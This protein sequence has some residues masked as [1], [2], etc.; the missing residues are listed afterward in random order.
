MISESGSSAS[1]LSIDLESASG[2]NSG[3]ALASGLGCSAS[4]RASC[5]TSTS[6]LVTTLRKRK[7][8]PQTWALNKRRQLRNSGNV[9]I[10]AKATISTLH[11]SH[12]LF[13]YFS[14]MCAFI[15][16]STLLF[17]PHYSLSTY[18]V[19]HR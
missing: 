14:L 12:A 9:Y 8:K 2:A 13:R 18:V 7:R 4:M 1:N 15:M 10:S 16:F 19:M 5:G 17:W 11:F 6:A 3:S